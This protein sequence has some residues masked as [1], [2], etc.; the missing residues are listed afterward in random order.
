MER[1]KAIQIYMKP[2]L[3]EDDLLLAVWEASKRHDRPQNVFR[4]M[5]RAGL[6]AMVEEG[7]MPE[8]IIEE[9]NLDDIV[10]RRRLRRTYRT[11]PAGGVYP[12]T[13]YA[14]PE[15]PYERPYIRRPAPAPSPV[16]PPSHGVVKNLEPARHESEL[17]ANPEASHIVEK[18]PAQ[19]LSDDVAKKQRTDGDGG[20]RGGKRIGALM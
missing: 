9:C 12:E 16:A 17:R 3:K 14:E 2:G 6:R 11:P 4:A 15:M 7:D 1:S 10:Q 19:S 5:L 13:A 18:G 20:K 8:A